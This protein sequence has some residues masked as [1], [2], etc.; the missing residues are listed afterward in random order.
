MTDQKLT[1]VDTSDDGRQ[2]TNAHKV[3]VTDDDGCVVDIEVS[4]NGEVTFEVISSP[5]FSCAMVDTHPTGVAILEKLIFVLQD[6]KNRQEDY[7][8]QQTAH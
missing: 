6:A 5:N 4:K 2:L 1:H 8:R 7:I 3:T